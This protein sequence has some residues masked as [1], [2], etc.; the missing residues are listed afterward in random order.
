MNHTSSSGVP[1]EQPV[2]MLLLAVA[3]FTVPVVFV[4]PN[5][6]VVAP[7]HS[8]LPGG[9]ILNAVVVKKKHNS[10]NA[11]TRGLDLNMAYQGFG[12]KIKA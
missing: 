2:G 3:L 12:L 4:T 7:A 9:G 8:S 10:K 1:V 6:R 11:I 5:V